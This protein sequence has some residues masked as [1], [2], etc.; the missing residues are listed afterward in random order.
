MPLSMSR[1]AAGKLRPS[2]ASAKPPNTYAGTKCGA[3]VVRMSNTC[4][5]LLEAVVGDAMLAVVLDRT[6]PRQIGGRLRV[7]ERR[8]PQV[9]ARR[10]VRQLLERP[11]AAAT[12]WYAWPEQH[13]GGGAEGQRQ[14]RW[15]PAMRCRQTGSAIT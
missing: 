6:Q 7:A 8:G 2:C 1:S 11:R 5:M 9:L 3:S 4:S 15:R 14:R 13:R 10:V 12:S